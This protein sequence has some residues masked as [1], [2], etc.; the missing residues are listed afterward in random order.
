MIEEY[1][2]LREYPMYRIYN[3]G[4]IYS[5]FSKKFLKRF[6]DNSG[7]L[8]VT[9]FKGKNLGR[10]TIKVHILVAKAFLPNPNNLPEV[11]HKNCNKCDNRVS[12][13]EWVSKK[14]NMLHAS[15]YSYNNR[16]ALSPLTKEKVLLIPTLLSKGFSIKLIST[17]YNVGHITIR[18]I[19]QRKTW[20]HLNLQFNKSEYSREIIKINNL[21]YNKLISLNV[22]NTVLNSRVKVLESV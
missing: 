9:L 20:K 15:K 10:K 7:Y 13:L 1:K 18:N 16:E 22:D 4:K 19:I 3:T 14:E 17:L 8:Q 5:E 2:K 6:D 11:N 21:L 12:N